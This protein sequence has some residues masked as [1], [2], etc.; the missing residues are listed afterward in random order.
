MT[1]HLPLSAHPPLRP[2]DDFSFL[3]EDFRNRVPHVLHALAVSTDGLLTAADR[4]LDRDRAE[5]LAAACA[6]LVSLLRN[7][8][9]GFGAGPLSHNLSEFAG[10]FMFTM[11]DTSGACLLVFADR[12][13]DLGTV[14]YEMTELVN[15]VGDALSPASRGFRPSTVDSYYA[16]LGG[17]S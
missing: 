17:S 3:L 16:P 1:T 7:A 14:S 8:G 6:G 13:C 9:D 2:P 12:D 5:R 10:G 15:R 11:A 4:N